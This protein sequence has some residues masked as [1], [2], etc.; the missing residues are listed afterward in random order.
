M[1][2]TRE[3]PARSA[4]AARAVRIERLY[5]KCAGALRETL[6]SSFGAPPDAAEAMVNEAFGA[7]ITS[8][9]HDEEA[10]VIA[11]ACRIATQYQA[12]QEIR[13][14]PDVLAAEARA[15]RDRV[16]VRHAI[17]T[18]P[19]RAQEAL[20]LRFVEGRTLAEVAAQLN[21]HL[22]YAKRLVLGSIDRLARQ[23][24]STE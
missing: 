12:A 23:G 14:P 6:Q 21:I 24:E 17:D 7:L 13:I 18:L 1:Q 15:I 3:N 2:P 4:S 22:R 9:A 16:V 10:Y 11:A 5:E 20:R 8:S 19:K